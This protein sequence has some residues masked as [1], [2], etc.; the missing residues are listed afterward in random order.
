MSRTHC[1]R[2]KYIKTKKTNGILLEIIREGEYKPDKYY[3][4]GLDIKV[5]NQTKNKKSIIVKPSIIG[6]KNIRKIIAK[7]FELS[8]SESTEL[9]FHSGKLK[10]STIITG[11]N[12]YIE[13]NQT[14]KTLT[15]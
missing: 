2:N 8:S 14:K 11:T 10:N 1:R 7:A 9:Y 13:I 3:R 4:I 5:T 6:K 12:I 15:F